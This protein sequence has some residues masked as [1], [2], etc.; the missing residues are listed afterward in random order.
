LEIAANIQQKLFPRKPAASS[1]TMPDTACPRAKSAAT[2][3]TSSNARPPIGFVLGTFRQSV[4][5]RLLMVTYR[6]ASA[7][8]R[9]PPAPAEVATVNRHFFNSTAAERF[10][11]LIFAIYDDATRQIRRELRHCPP[12][13]LAPPANWRSLDSSHH[14]RRLTIGAAAK[15]PPLN[16]GDTLCFIPTASPKPE[17][18]AATIRPDLIHVACQSVPAAEAL[19]RPS[20]TT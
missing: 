15:V 7:N 9:T 10:A 19:V 5:R 12:L 13:L 3:T 20:S 14:A 4:P 1:L 2:I 17:P 11:T 16:P 18:T 8:R 6:P